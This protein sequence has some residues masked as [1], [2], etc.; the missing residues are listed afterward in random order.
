MPLGGI[1]CGSIGRGWKGDFNRWQLTPG[2]YSYDAVH[3][4]Q[5]HA[6][7]IDCHTSFKESL[8]MFYLYVFIVC[9]LHKK[10]GKNRVPGWIKFCLLVR[11]ARNKV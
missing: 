4:N 6:G 11:L 5:V 10:K 7:K 9:S 2:M 8:C 1:G 3:A